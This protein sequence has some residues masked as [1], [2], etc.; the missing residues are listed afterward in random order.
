VVGRLAEGDVAIF[1]A[2]RNEA[3]ASHERFQT[4]TGLEGDLPQQ[5]SAHGFVRAPA[6]DMRLAAVSVSNP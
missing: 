6:E 2:R 3:Q 4:R 5:I 1:L